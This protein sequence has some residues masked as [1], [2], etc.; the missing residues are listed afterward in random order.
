MVGDLLAND[1]CVKA[2]LETVFKYTNFLHDRT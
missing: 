2:A 1:F